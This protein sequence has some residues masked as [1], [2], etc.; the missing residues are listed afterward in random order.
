M[1][2]V[3]IKG[4]V[5]KIAGTGAGAIGGA[6]ANKI[7][8]VGNLSPLIRGIGK[9]AIGGFVLPMVS[10]DKNIENV[11]NGLISVGMIELA[12]ATLFKASP[13]AL[14][15][16]TDGL[17]TLGRIPGKRVYIDEKRMAGVNDGLPTLGDASGVRTGTY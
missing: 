2:K 17:P 11:G 9:V 7:A 4:S 6:Y 13:V 14:S 1:K 16:V 5:M 15:G 3:D 12:N 10:K 8:F